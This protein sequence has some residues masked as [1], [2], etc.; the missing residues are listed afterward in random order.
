LN[1]LQTESSYPAVRDKD[2]FSQLIPLPPLPEQHRIVSEIE[3]L[4]SE[5]DKGIESLKTAQQQLKVYR[6]AVLK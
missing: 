3:E 6:Q 5:L 4:F 2:V 1:E